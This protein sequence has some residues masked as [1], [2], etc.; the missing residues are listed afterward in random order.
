MYKFVGNPTEYKT[1]LIPQKGMTYEADTVLDPLHGATLG[2]I[3]QAAQIDLAIGSKFKEEA[4][5]FL[6][7]WENGNDI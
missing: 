3:I 1:D 6:N 2:E 4:R 7:D 5:Q